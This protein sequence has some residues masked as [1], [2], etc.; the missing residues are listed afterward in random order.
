MISFSVIF[1]ATSFVRVETIDTGGCEKF[2]SLGK[3]VGPTNERPFS[4]PF[5]GSADFGDIITIALNRLE[6]RP[7]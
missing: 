3:K 2:T 5:D 4:E 6:S 1:I 7:C